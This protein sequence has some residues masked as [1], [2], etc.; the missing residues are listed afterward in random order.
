MRYDYLL[1]CYVCFKLQIKMFMNQIS[2]CDSD[3]ISAF[4]FFDIN[5]N[6]VTTVSYKVKYYTCVFF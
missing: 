1:C 2:V 3:Q 4:G 5:L 6:L